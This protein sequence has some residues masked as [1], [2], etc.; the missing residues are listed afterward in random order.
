VGGGE[1]PV[2]SHTVAAAYTQSMRLSDSLTLSV[3]LNTKQSHDSLI[4]QIVT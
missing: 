2:F 1:I 4:K 3:R